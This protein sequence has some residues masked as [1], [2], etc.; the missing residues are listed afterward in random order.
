MLSV[1]RGHGL[2]AVDSAGGCVGCS[3]LSGAGGCATSFCDLVATG[4]TTPIVCTLRGSA[5]GFVD[6]TA[7]CVGSVTPATACAG[8]CSVTKAYDQTGNTNH[9]T[10][11]TAAQMPALLFGGS[12]SG[13]LPV[14]NCASAGTSC[15]MTTTNTFTSS[16]FATA[17]TF[18]GAGVYIR[19]GINGGAV[20]S[21]SNA[22]QFL[23]ANTANA[24][25]VAN[26]TIVNSS[27]AAN[28]GSWHATQGLIAPGAC[29]LDVNGTDQTGMA[30]GS[31]GLTA[32]ALRIF[33][34]GSGN[35]MAAS[36]AESMFWPLTSTAANRQA[37]SANAHT[38]YGF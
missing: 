37:V 26:N 27:T 29:A 34:T 5:T 6:L 3:D 21:T 22:Y 18:T 8:G 23:V 7:Y 4:T 31:V 9:F 36:I 28:D 12:P 15:N 2:V 13:T 25:A 1:D 10:Q 24:A 14:M 32:V 30:C 19:T 16:G 20:I 11:T 38:R 17:N 35:Q 33:R